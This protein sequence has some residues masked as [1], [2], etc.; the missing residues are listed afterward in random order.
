MSPYKNFENWG[1]SLSAFLFFSLSLIVP[2]G[3][4]YGAAALALLALAGC[5]QKGSHGVASLDTKILLASLC[6]TGMLWT[7]PFDRAWSISGLGIGAKYAFAA[8]TLWAL[9]QRV[10]SPHAVVWGVAAGAVGALGIAAYQY[11]VLHWVKAQGFTNAIEYGGIAMYM[12]IAAWA[13]AMLG[14]W[15]WHQIAALGICGA[16]GVL[17]SLLSESRGSWVT[18][19]LLLAAIWLMAWR[20]GYRRIASAAIAAMLIGGAALVLPAYKK[21][22]QRADLAVQEARHYLAE[23]Q[24]YA[25]TSIGQRLEQWRLAVDLIEERPVAGWG[26]DGYPKAKQA[27]VD[28]GAA[29][30]SVMQYGHAHNEILDMWVKRGLIGLLILLF[31]YAAPLYVFWPTPRRLARVDTTLQPRLLALRAAAAL[32]PLAYFGFGWTQVFFA[33]NSGQMFYIFSLAI[34]W[35]AICYLEKTEANTWV[36]SG[37]GEVQHKARPVYPNGLRCPLN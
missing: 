23:P 5:L 9:S 37:H 34:F 14:R 36:V 16:C 25:E 1:G 32:L 6:L 27:M 12:G 17:A 22:E 24:K 8:L 30:P 26:L 15:R 7:A 2:S 29:H 35:G 21:F 11:L 13:M 19:P 28:K 31:F 20:N 10:L 3:Y 18:V 33:H 4:S